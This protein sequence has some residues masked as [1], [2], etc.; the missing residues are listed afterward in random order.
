MLYQVSHEIITPLNCIVEMLEA[1]TQ[2]VIEN[3]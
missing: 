2:N 1:A 3:N